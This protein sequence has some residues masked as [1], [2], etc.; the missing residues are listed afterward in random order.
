MDCRDAYLN[1]LLGRALRQHRH[2]SL[3]SRFADRHRATVSAGGHGDT[4]L[5][6]RGGL[7]ALHYVQSYAQRLLADGGAI[8]RDASGAIARFDD[9][10]I[11]RGLSPRGS[12]DLLA[13]TWFLS[14]FGD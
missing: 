8:A 5:V 6:A 7:S 3:C 9:A 1:E 11:A 13:V 4:N 14:R 2:R 12:A 10:L